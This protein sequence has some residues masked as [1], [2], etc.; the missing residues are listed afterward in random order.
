MY[1]FKGGKHS[2]LTYCRLKYAFVSL[3]LLNGKTMFRFSKCE[4]ENLVS[5]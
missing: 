3:K 2:T 1:K 5:N 4:E